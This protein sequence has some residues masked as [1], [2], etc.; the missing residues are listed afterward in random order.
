MRPD[1]LDHLVIESK[2]TQS[3][4][5]TKGSPLPEGGGSGLSITMDQGGQPIADPRQ[6]RTWAAHR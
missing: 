4:A 5:S 6:G 3:D 1:C 2:R